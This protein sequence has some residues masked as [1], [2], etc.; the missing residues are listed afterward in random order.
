MTTEDKGSGTAQEEGT[1]VEDAQQA[2]PDPQQAD[3][4]DKQ[5]ETSPPS[6]ADKATPEGEETEQPEKL[7]RD[8]KRKAATRE[9]IKVLTDE[10]RTLQERRERITRAGERETPP[11]PE[12]FEDDTDFA[13]AKAVFQHA[14]RQ[15]DRELEEIDAQSTAQEERIAQERNEAFELQ[16]SHARTRYSDYDAVLRTLPS[17]IGK[18]EL[19]AEAILSS[20]VGADLAYFLAKNPAKARGIAKMDEHEMWKAIGALETRLQEAPARKAAQPAVPPEPVETLKGGASG[21][22]RTVYDAGSYDEHRRIRR[23]QLKNANV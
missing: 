6:E 4:A 9:R 1:P 14:K 2:G 20:D 5:T 13:A 10:V 21:K 18:S 22:A 12:D 16:V 3:E 17:A 15:R 11:K 19:M 23:E 7:S 8:Q